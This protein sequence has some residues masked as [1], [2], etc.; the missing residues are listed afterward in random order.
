METTKQKLAELTITRIFDAPRKLVWKMWTDPELIMRWWGPKEYSSP[1]C[2]I[3]FR[4][5]GKY[6]FCMRPTEGRDIFSTGIYKKIDP[7]NQIVCTDCFA[8]ENGNVVPASHYGMTD[9]IPLELEITIKF[10]DFDGKTRMTLTHAGLPVGE[11]IE[12]ANIGWN[13]SFDKF[14]KVLTSL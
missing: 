14:E 1:V 3:D 13:E 2:K 9:D 5:G 8:D 11:Q 7:F 4:I 12:G 10:E 6:V